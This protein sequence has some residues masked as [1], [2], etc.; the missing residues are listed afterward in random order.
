MEEGKPVNQGRTALEEMRRGQF[1]PPQPVLVQVGILFSM[2]LGCLAA[3]L[4]VAAVIGAESDI[5]RV[6]AAAPFFLILFLGY[7]LWLLRA[8]VILIEGIGKGLLSALFTL[9]VRRDRSIRMEDVLP[10]SSV[11][12]ELAAKVQIAASSFRVVSL[13][14]ALVWIFL[15]LIIESWMPAYLLLVTMVLSCIGWGQLLTMLGQRGYLPISDE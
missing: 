3:G 5:A 15:G 11:R 9:L 4:G 8:K 14:V 10:N 13:L 7:S 1:Y 12:E 2:F 6:F